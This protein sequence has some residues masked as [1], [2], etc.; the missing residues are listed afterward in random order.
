M[1][2]FNSLFLTVT[3]RNDD[4]VKVD[5]PLQVGTIGTFIEI[6]HPKPPVPP[7]D[8]LNSMPTP[9]PVFLPPP[10]PANPIPPKRKRG[11]SFHNGFTKES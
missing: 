10:A 5:A 6:E 1:P 8:N 4:E 7:G 9:E 3:V 11:W 2:G